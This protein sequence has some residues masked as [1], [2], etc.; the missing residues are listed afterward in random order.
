MDNYNIA[1]ANNRG[2]LIFS[3]IIAMIMSSFILTEFCFAQD[4]QELENFDENQ[5]N[6]E[7]QEN[8]EI[9]ENQETATTGDS[10]PE[11]SEDTE[12]EASDGLVDRIIFSSKSFWEFRALP[13]LT[14]AGDRLTNLWQFSIEPKI[15]IAAE[16]TYSA[17]TH[18]VKP[19]VPNSINKTKKFVGI[20]NR[21]TDINK[22]IEKEVEEMKQESPYLYKIFEKYEGFKEFIWGTNGTSTQETYKSIK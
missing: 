11:I 7:N 13:C 10:T 14:K 9:D 3:I 19:F 2:A 5:E 17:W 16:W 20:E 22:E 21:K 15:N 6:V 12:V 1:N 18:K 8:G 4:L